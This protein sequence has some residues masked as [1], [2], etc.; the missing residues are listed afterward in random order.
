MVRTTSRFLSMNSIHTMTWLKAALTDLLPIM[1]NQIEHLFRHYKD[2]E[3]D[4][5]VKGLRWVVRGD[6]Y[7]LI[8]R[9]ISRFHT[10]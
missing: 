7:A 6:A 5:M 1:R 3:K 8:R 9:A 2:L 10:T 4:K